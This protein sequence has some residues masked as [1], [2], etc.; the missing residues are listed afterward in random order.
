MI[1]KNPIIFPEDPVLFLNFEN[2]DTKETDNI[3]LHIDGRDFNKEDGKLYYSLDF[4]LPNGFIIPNVRG[5]HVNIFEKKY[6]KIFTICPYTVKLRNEAL[7]K[8]LYH[9]TYYPSPTSWTRNN[10]KIYDLIYVGGGSDYLLT[11]KILKYNYLVVNKF[12]EKYTN[13]FNVTFNEKLNLISKSKIAIVHNII[14][15]DLNGWDLNA[16]D[17][18]LNIKNGIGF[19]SIT[20]HKS[21]VI[22]AARCGTLI[23]C[24]EDDFNIIEDFFEPNVDFIYFN[25]YNFD[26]IVKDVLENYESEK[27]QKIINSA[28]NKVDTLYNIKNFYNDNIKKNE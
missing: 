22:E 26:D 27:Y 11:D 25:D 7:G 13:I 17:S 6:D 21:R 15:V 4:E 16:G 20:Q 18:F 10:D 28:Y 12:H 14:R 3:E 8:E 19:P 2:I 24:K 5:Q 23:L 9:Y 1:V